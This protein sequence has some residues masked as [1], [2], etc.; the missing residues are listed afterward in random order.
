MTAVDCPTGK[1]GYQ[2]RRI[3]QARLASVQQIEHHQER[4]AYRCPWCGAWHLTSDGRRKKKG[5]RR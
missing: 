3:A 2:H 5:R 4:K 1:I